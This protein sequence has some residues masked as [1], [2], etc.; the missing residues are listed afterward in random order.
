MTFDK[1]SH[2]HTLTIVNTLLRTCHPLTPR[3]IIGRKPSSAAEQLWKCYLKYKKDLGCAMF[4]MEF[5]CVYRWTS[6]SNIY[7]YIYIHIYMVYIY[8]IYKI[9]IICYP[10]NVLSIC[11]S[12]NV[13]SIWFPRCSKYLLRTPYRCELVFIPKD[14]LS[15]CPSIYVKSYLPT[16]YYVIIS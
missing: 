12:L 16:S 10:W 14:V 5:T 3:V 15:T 4:S 2:I 13:L 9:P 11:F 8:I 1:S 7:R 6:T